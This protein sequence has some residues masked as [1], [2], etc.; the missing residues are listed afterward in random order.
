MEHNSNTDDDGYPDEMLNNIIEEALKPKVETY[1]FEPIGPR[2]H[3]TWLVEEKTPGDVPSKYYFLRFFDEDICVSTEAVTMDFIR[4]N[5]TIPVA[6]IVAHDFRQKNVTFML[7]GHFR[8]IERMRFILQEYVPQKTLE[9]FGDTLSREQWLQLARELG[10]VIAKLWKLVHEYHTNQER[11]TTRQPDNTF[12][13]DMIRGDLRDEFEPFRLFDVHYST[14][15]SEEEEDTD[16]SRV[17]HLID[18][19]LHVLDHFGLFSYGHFYLRHIFLQPRNILVNPKA[20]SS[21]PIVTGFVSWSP[22]YFPPDVPKKTHIV[23][24]DDFL[25]NS[26]WLWRYSKDENRGL[27][28][29][30]EAQ[31]KATTEKETGNSVET[32]N[33]NPKKEMKNSLRREIAD[34]LLR[35]REHIKDKTRGIHS[36]KKNKDKDTPKTEEEAGKSGPT[37]RES[38]IEEKKHE[39]VDGNDVDG[40][41]DGKMYDEELRDAFFKEA[42]VP[43]AELVDSRDYQFGVKLVQFVSHK[44]HLNSDDLAKAHKLIEEWLTHQPVEVLDEIRKRMDFEF[45]AFLAWM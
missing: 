20:T 18:V 6:K 31:H 40:N 29:Q 32:D 7:D 27:H 34:N 10:T 35:F 45:R 16:A 11:T 13:M 25:R 2:S 17:S 4:E 23:S 33:E 43:Y 22:Y 42:G 5:T 44:T 28:L 38:Q 37:A 30:R 1:R 19:I 14:A 15:Y 26:E 41:E 8:K 24:R 36:K 9:M 39:T 3:Y 12:I 21:E